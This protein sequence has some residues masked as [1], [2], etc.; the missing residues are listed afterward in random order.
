MNFSAYF[1]SRAIEI[2]FNIRIYVLTQKNINLYS[3]E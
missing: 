1:Y 2:K 3:M